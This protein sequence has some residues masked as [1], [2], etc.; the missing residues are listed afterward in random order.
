MTHT[1]PDG[2][3]ADVEITVNYRHKLSALNPL[4]PCDN[5]QYGITIPTNTFVDYKWS[6]EI[7][8]VTI[9]G[10]DLVYEGALSSVGGR[11]FLDYEGLAA[12]RIPPMNE[13][14]DNGVAVT[15]RTIEVTWSNVPR[16]PIDVVNWCSG[17]LNE[18][19]FLGFP[20]ES[21]LFLMP[22]FT[23]KAT[24]YGEH[25]YD[26]HYVFIA[27]TI[28]INAMSQWTPVEL[29]YWNEG[30]IGVWNRRWCEIPEKGTDCFTNP[31]YNYFH[32][33][34]SRTGG[35]RPY[36]TAEFHDLFDFQP[37]AGCV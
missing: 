20:P 37:P 14:V 26:I 12:D 18:T 34:K 2:G 16:I 23:P 29:D 1:C 30:M 5:L 7:D 33:V 27:K 24:W 4:L 25:V 22:E 17:R 32:K 35:D 11:T 36:Q 3:I 28:S 15:T 31:Q 9:K 8:V 19:Q 6:S 10:R 13:D 21:V